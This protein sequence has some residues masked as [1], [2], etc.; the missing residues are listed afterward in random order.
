MATCHSHTLNPQVSI[1]HPAHETGKV[2]FFA[3]WGNLVFGI[4]FL[5]EVIEVELQSFM[6]LAKEQN[7][8]FTAEQ[9]EILVRE[10]ANAS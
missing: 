7:V 10:A 5:G 1:D 4:P 6:L 3:V 8:Q 2:E 9:A